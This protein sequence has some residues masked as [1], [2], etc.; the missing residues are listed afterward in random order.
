MF[1]SASHPQPDPNGSQKELGSAMSSNASSGSH[2][3]PL[4]PPA[5]LAARIEEA[6]S[7]AKLLQQLVQSTAPHEVQSNDLIHEFGQRVWAAQKSMRSYINNSDPPPDRAT[8]EQLIQTSEL[9]SVAAS[10]H[11]RAVL[12]SRQQFGDP[13]APSSERRSQS[14]VS[15]QSRP[16]Q[17]QEA[18]TT[19]IRSALESDIPAIA[20]FHQWYV[21]NTVI[22]FRT[23]PTTVTELLG[24][25]RKLKERGL[26]YLVAVPSSDY[27]DTSPTKSRSE[28]PVVLG[29]T[30]CSGFRSAKAG[31]AHTGELSLFCHPECRGRG[32]G[33]LLLNELI[34]IL[35]APMLYTGLNVGEYGV[36]S[37]IACMAL[38][39]EGK[40]RGE[41]LVKWYERFGFVERG[42][43]KKVGYKFGR[44]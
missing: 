31:Y 1:P 17:Y 24:H 42:R 15:A 28:T 38:D 27:D 41:G 11:Q 7:S 22:T 3:G 2:A 12:Q 34:S 44:W 35:K 43:L 14:I 10:K 33:G 8:L 9:L 36:R 40:E 32:I 26:P 19:M 4:P 5:E 39:T 37:L 18:D 25:Y 29:F 16:R 30:Y 6:K 21:L 20:A 23:E 13:S